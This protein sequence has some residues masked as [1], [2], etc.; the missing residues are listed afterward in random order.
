VKATTN[1]RD[2]QSVGQIL[3]DVLI[4]KSRVPENVEW[5]DFYTV[6]MEEIAFNAYRDILP[7]LLFEHW[8]K[9]SGEYETISQDDRLRGI[10]YLVSQRQRNTFQ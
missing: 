3:R 9:S 5:L 7:R 10:A 8:P 6:M 1:V 2:L 4:G